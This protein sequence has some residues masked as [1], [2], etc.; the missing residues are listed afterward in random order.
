MKRIPLISAIGVVCILLAV[1][2]VTIP[3]P[4]YEA[5][6]AYIDYNSITA[7][8][9]VFLTEASAISQTYE[10]LGSVSAYVQDGYIVTNISQVNDTI[11]DP[12]YGKF[13]TKKKDKI[14]YGDYKIASPSEAVYLAAKKAKEMGANGIINLQMRTYLGERPAYV[15]TGMA[16]KIK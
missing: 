14:K 13:I 16:I 1:S 9:G 12:L 8:T 4:T 5:D 2:C 3:K 11:D 15:V 10:G 7:K 6:V